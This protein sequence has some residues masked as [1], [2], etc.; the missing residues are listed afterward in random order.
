MIK[1]IGKL[2]VFFEDPFWIGVF[3]RIYEGELSVSK[4]VFGEEPSDRELCEFITKHYGD[5]K[6]SPSIK[7]DKRQTTDNPKRR[8]RDAS[9]QLKNTGI[10]TKS[11]QALKLQQEAMKTERKQIT[12]EQKEIEAKKRFEAKR[13]KQKEKRRGH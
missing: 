1:S 7:V 9:K 4:V 6:F 3:E 10:G 5:L 2:T 8:Q 11:Q 12:K 13:L